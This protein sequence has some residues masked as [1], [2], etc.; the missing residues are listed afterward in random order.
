MKWG[1]IR[2]VMA[3]WRP[4]VK[5]GIMGIINAALVRHV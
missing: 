2:S 1:M 3:T 4:D 5:L